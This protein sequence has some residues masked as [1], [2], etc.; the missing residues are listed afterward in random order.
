MFQVH[1]IESYHAPDNY[2]GIWYYSLWL[3]GMF[4]FFL[5]IKICNKHIKRYIQRMAKNTF[6][7]Y[8]MHLPILLYYTR[9]H[10][11]LKFTQVVSYVLVLFFIINIISETFKKL[12]VL[13]KLTQ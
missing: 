4:I 2:Y 11:I 10:P 9:N 13:R 12:P 3:F 8:M 5:N 7:V 1:S 6:A